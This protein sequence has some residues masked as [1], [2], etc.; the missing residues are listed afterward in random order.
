MHHDNTE[1]EDQHILEEQQHMQQQQQQPLSLAQ[2]QMNEK[3]KEQQQIIMQV[4]AEA[5]LHHQQMRLIEQQQ[6]L[7]QKQKLEQQ[8]QLEQM[9]SSQF[10]KEISSVEHQIE[11][12]SSQHTDSRVYSAEVPNASDTPG[13]KDPE[14]TCEDDRELPSQNTSIDVEPE[15]SAQQHLVELQQ[16]Q[17]SD[18]E[19]VMQEQKLNQLHSHSGVQPI[20]TDIA[21]D[22]I[23][24]DI[25]VQSLNN[26]LQPSNYQLNKT[27]DTQTRDENGNT[28]EDEF[29][30]DSIQS[31]N[32]E[33][34]AQR[35]A[36]YELQQQ[37][38]YQQQRGRSFEDKLCR[39]ELPPSSPIQARKIDCEA[40]ASDSPQ[41][42][43]ASSSLSSILSGAVVGNS[44][45]YSDG[46][47]VR[48]G[49]V[50]VSGSAA[51]PIATSSPHILPS[52][53]SNGSLVNSQHYDS[54]SLGSSPHT[55]APRPVHNSGHHSNLHHHPS[56]DYSSH[57]NSI[58][59]NNHA[60]SHS[61]PPHATSP[62]I[63]NGNISSLSSSTLNL[64]KKQITE[65]EREIALRK[66]EGPG[67]MSLANR[68]EE[69]AN[70]VHPSLDLQ[71]LDPL[72]KYLFSD[73]LTFKLF[74]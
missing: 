74:Y 68:C 5:K 16:Q 7:E 25:S 55:S 30:V 2:M 22:R 57:I 34:N 40:S 21:P 60:S 67:G 47:S 41:R 59:M 73:L 71:L 44:H 27:K 42:H 48:G 26:G 31:Y 56:L 66:P 50:C 19:Q 24:E 72:S 1:A 17:R 6:Q 18:L 43:M 46:R 3:L 23:H 36:E 28:P 53:C 14:T 54:L 52:N 45:G 64:M 15:L 32:A 9:Q 70:L 51:P 62:S 37:I 33:L 13:A 35:Q 12:S 69:V 63:N 61:T 49:D 38:H 20:L 29:K 10:H 8:K 39:G 4:Q 65:I 58:H 11:G